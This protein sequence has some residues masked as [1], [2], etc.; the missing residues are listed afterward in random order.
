MI[1]KKKK[2]LSLAKSD[3]SPCC[4][5]LIHPEDICTC[6]AARH[7]CVTFLCIALA[8]CKN[9]YAMYSYFLVMKNTICHALNVL[10]MKFLIVHMFWRQVFLKA[11]WIH[12]LSLTIKFR[13]RWINVMCM[14]FT[15]GVKN[16]FNIRISYCSLIPCLCDCTLPLWF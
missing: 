3:S 14:N 13:H 11:L 5:S 6:S 12:K 8:G 4:K 1:F 16:Y 2:F 10:L 15:R 7:C 9:K